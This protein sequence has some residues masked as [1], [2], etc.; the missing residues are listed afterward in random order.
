[1][2]TYRIG[3][4]QDVDLDEIRSEDSDFVFETDE[5]L[6]EFLKNRLC[7]D[8]EGLIINNDLLLNMS[9]HLINEGE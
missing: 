3:I 1:M 9:D 5:G 4:W 7:E 6:I 8:I 2:A